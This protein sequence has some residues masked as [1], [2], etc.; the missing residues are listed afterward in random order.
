MDKP[1]RHADIQEIPKKWVQIQEK[2]RKLEEE[3]FRKQLGLEN[4]DCNAKIKIGHDS[5]EPSKRKKKKKKKEQET[6]KGEK[7]LSTVE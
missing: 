3:Q 7:L 2:T 1:P 4:P 5:G 6:R